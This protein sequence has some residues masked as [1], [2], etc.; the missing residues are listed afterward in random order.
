MKRF[1]EL[2]DTPVSSPLS[3]EDIF[4]LHAA[5]LVLLLKHCG[6]KTRIDGL[7]KLAKLD[8]FVRYPD[9]FGKAAQTIGAQ[10]LEVS[11]VSES[12]MVRY[13]Y[14]PWD[15]R[16]Y[17]LLSYLE[18]TNLI[19]VVRMGNSYRITLTQN[20]NEVATTISKDSSHA[21]LIQHMKNVKKVMG[22]KGGTTLKNLI[23]ELFDTE[24]AARSLGEVIV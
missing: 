14:G 1:R 20:G 11:V 4:E 3:A 19:N 23:Y 9:F 10:S 7:T 8:F 24:I 21:T 18:S 16:Y 6:V 5:R 13:R 2:G 15:D 17:H 22:S 12:S